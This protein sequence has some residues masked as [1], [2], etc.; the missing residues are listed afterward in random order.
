MPEQFEYFVDATKAAEFLS[1]SRKHVLKLSK[2]GIIP[3]HPLGIGTRK[4]WRYLLS[5]LRAYVLAQGA[6]P[7]AET[8][9]ETDSPRSKQDPHLRRS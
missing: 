9:T 2:Q 7:D 3:A 1:F 6:S 4:T 8:A 5:E